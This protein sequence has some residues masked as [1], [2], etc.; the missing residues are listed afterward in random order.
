MADDAA[1]AM[2]RRHARS[3]DIPHRLDGRARRPLPSRSGRRFGSH[4]GDSFGST[5]R[6]NAVE[7]R[8]CL[9]HL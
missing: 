6:H 7:G 1:T 2:T 8:V 4:H 5:V 9:G 3:L